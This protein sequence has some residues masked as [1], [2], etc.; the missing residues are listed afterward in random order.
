M[1]RSGYIVITS[2]LSLFLHPADNTEFRKR[3]FYSQFVDL[4]RSVMSRSRYIVITSTL[5]LFLHQ[6]SMLDAEFRKREFYSQFVDL[7]RSV[8]SRSRYIVITSKLSL[9]LHQHHAEFRKTRIL[10]VIY[11]MLK[12]T[13]LRST[14][15]SWTLE[16]RTVSAVKQKKN[17][18]VVAVA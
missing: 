14:C 15:V 3:E 6:H 16:N 9:L 7:S 4:S 17:A 1:S 2:T 18:S 12:N 10:E 13:S 11:R 8:M 5:S